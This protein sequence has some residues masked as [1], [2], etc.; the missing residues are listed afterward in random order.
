MAGWLL[1]ANVNK[2]N[3]KL[4]VGGGWSDLYQNDF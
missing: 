2:F 3:L 1:E 4:N